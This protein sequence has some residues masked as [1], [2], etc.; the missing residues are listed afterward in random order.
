MRL[1]IKPYV[2]KIYFDNRDYDCNHEPITLITDA[3]GLT[4][5]KKAACFL[6]N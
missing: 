4:V 3:S 2:E 6:F 5:S 1:K